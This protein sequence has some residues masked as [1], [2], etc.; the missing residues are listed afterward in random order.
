VIQVQTVLQS[1]PNSV[2]EE[3]ILVLG[4]ADINHDFLIKIKNWICLFVKKRFIFD[5]NQI[6]IYIKIFV[7]CLIVV[8]CLLQLYLCKQSS[9]YVI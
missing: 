2:I 6:L 7:E 3:G 4:R 1:R 5:L 9:T 8:S